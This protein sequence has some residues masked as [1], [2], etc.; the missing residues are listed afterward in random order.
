MT[1]QGTQNW[2]RGWNLTEEEREVYR[3]RSKA[4]SKARRDALKGQGPK[5]IHPVNIPRLDT[6]I[7]MPQLPNNGLRTLSLF[8]G[9]GGL[10]LGF[11]RAGFKHVASYDIL[12]AA[13]VTLQKNRPEWRI[14]AGKDGD[15]TK[16]D[17]TLYRGE[18]D[19]VH[20]GP[21]CQPF[22]LAGRQQGKEDPRDMF[23]TFVRAVLEIEPLAFIAENVPALV[24][25]K[26]DQ[27]LQ[28][29]IETPLSSKYFIRKFQLYAPCFGIPQVRKRVFFVGFKK[30][31]LAVKYQEPTL[32]HY[33]N[34]LE[35]KTIVLESLIQ[36]NLQP[37]MGAR[38]ALGLPDIG[39]D[40]LAP[41][42]RSGFTGPRHT[43]S[44][45][46]SVSA[47]K[48]WRKL[49]IWPNGVALTRERAS[50]FVVENEDFRLSVPDCVLLQGFPESWSIQGAV[51]VALGQIGNAV[52]PPMAYR[53]AKSILNTFS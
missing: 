26:F 3:K 48:A 7:L 51:Y 15:V 33:Y 13:G 43:T 28:E 44:V 31:N 22:S 10:D 21:P 30:A 39:I 14:F 52:P 8:S 9:G 27:Y 37:C 25:K 45:L 19:I 24:T 11:E 42:I 16:I 20:G 46:S 53:V 18:I 47:Q 12:E 29:V 34:H 2:E 50:I 17:W 49:G 35:E 32:T 41:T 40:G 38:E 1:F 36:H 4:S 5:P 23:P 6:D